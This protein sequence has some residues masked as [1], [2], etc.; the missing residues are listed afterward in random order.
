PSTPN[1]NNGFNGYLDS[2]CG[3]GTN[4]CLHVVSIAS[5]NRAAF[6]GSLSYPVETFSGSIPNN[7]NVM[8]V[9]GNPSPNVGTV[10]VGSVISGTSIPGNTYI[11]ANGS[12]TGNGG[13]YDL[14]WTNTTGSTTTETMT[15][16]QAMFPATN[17][18]SPTVLTV[19]S[20]TG[21]I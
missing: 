19:S 5:A 20:G 9:T 10:L 11:T 17:F 8:T 18:L 16:A 14:N 12:G 1:T 4:Q 15:I 7:S 13:T 21:I 2:A 6:T 3:G